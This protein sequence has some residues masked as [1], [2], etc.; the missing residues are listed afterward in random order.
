MRREALLSV[1]IERYIY[2]E[3]TLV[4][5]EPVKCPGSCDWCR[6]EQC[7]PGFADSNNLTF[8][9]STASASCNMSQTT[10][11]LT[12][13][14]SCDAITTSAIGD[15]HVTSVTGEKFDLWKTG[16]STF[17]QIPKDVIPNSVSKLVVEG[18]VLPYSGDECAAAFL[19]N[20]KMTG[21]MV[22]NN[23]ILVR[24]GPLDGATPFGVSLDGSD[25]EA[26]D[27]GSDMFVGRS[28]SS[29]GMISD[30]EPGFW[31][32]DLKLKMKL[33]ETTYG[34]T[35]GGQPI[36]VGYSLWMA[37]ILTQCLWLAWGRWCTDGWSGASRMR[38][39]RFHCGRSAP[40]E[41]SPKRIGKFPVATRQV[42]LSSCEGSGGRTQPFFTQRLRP[43]ETTAMTVGTDKTVVI[44]GQKC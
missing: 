16:W 18:N 30:E 23:E 41:E 40:T 44:E 2:Q 27:T 5:S 3:E 35:L 42:G 17:V 24:K 33:G 26:V 34:G 31:G 43:G 13:S 11:R 8:P 28:L 20:V 38:R 6:A 10:T 15:P 21:S 19:K 25:F 9:C 1:R 39:N 36:D 4:A 37:S 29:K 7:C 12:H 32:H 22:D 14:S